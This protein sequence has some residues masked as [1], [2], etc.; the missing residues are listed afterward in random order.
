[1]KNRFFLIRLDDACPTMSHS[2]WHKME[3]LLDKYGIKPLVGVIPCNEDSKQMIDT[4]DNN[5]WEKVRCWQ[6]KEWA[7]ALHGYNHVYSSTNPG[8]L[9]FWKKSEFAGN[10]YETQSEKIIKGL[11]VFKKHN[12]VPEFFFAP[13][14]T[15]DAI[16]LL[17]L[18]NNSNIRKISDGIALTPY[19]QEGMCFIPQISG[20]CLSIPWKGVFTF[21]FHP[22]TMSMDDFTSL[23]KFLKKHYKEFI[24]FS[25]LQLD[26]YGNMT[27]FDKILHKVYFAYRYIRGMK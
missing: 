7:I 19:W 23:E 18:K 21:C 25:A 16:T 6:N 1:M 22:N 3:I 5:F 24:P 4:F 2:R 12:I 20:H 15:F 26:L 27:L 9:P 8:I 11:S 14:H 10:S 13:S 17:A